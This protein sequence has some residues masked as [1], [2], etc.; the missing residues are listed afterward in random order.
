MGKYQYYV[1][2]AANGVFIHS[3]PKTAVR[4]RDKYFRSPK[5]YRGYNSLRE[6]EIEA[7]D[8]LWDITPLDRELPDHLE[9]D[10]LYY[11]HRF[12]KN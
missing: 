6:A 3:D 1:V 10:K 4:C 12:P 5:I 2:F 11:P 8:H 9:I 7:L